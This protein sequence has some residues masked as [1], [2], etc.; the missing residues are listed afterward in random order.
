MAEPNFEIDAVV[1]WVDK[2]LLNLNPF[3]DD[4]LHYQYWL[5]ALRMMKMTLVVSG[6]EALG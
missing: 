2:Y 1:D 5:C 3:R 6:R 4:S